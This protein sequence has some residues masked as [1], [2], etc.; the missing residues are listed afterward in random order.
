MPPTGFEH[1]LTVISEAA[2]QRDLPN[3]CYLSLLSSCDHASFIEA[4]RRGASSSTLPPGSTQD[5]FVND[6]GEVWA[7]V[8]AA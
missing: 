1:A 2:Q 4:L 7:R 3:P 5:I 8:T 6:F